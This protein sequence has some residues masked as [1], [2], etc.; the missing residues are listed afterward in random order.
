MSRWLELKKVAVPETWQ[1][2]LFQPNRQEK[3]V[4]SVNLCSATGRLLQWTLEQPPVPLSGVLYEQG[5]FQQDQD[6]Q[7]EAIVYCIVKG[8]GTSRLVAHRLTNLQAS[9]NQSAQQV[10]QTPFLYI[11]HCGVGLSIFY[12]ESLCPGSGLGGEPDSALVA[13]RLTNLQAS[14][15]QSAQQV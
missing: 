13:H 5:Q 11:Y 4:F 7:C 14:R 15:N 2:W 1:H 9:R 10:S 6:L 12:T 3:A 8:S